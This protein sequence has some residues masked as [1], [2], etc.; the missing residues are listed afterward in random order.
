MLHHELRQPQIRILETLAASPTPLNR[1]ELSG[2]TGIQKDN[3]G[4]YLGSSRL[5]VRWL[6]DFK[7]LSLLSRGL[8]EVASHDE[9]GDRYR[10][11]PDGELAILP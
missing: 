7:L 3:L 8:I 4:G 9:R 6:E 2:R 5:G 10:I 11:T 1:A